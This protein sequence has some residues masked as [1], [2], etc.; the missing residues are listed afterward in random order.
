LDDGAEGVE[1]FLDGL[2]VSFCDGREGE[3]G[4]A[5]FGYVYNSGDVSGDGLKRT[6]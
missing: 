2:L 6:R 5:G 3:V 1:D 4:L